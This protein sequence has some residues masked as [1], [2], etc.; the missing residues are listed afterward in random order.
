MKI[1]QILFSLV[2]LGMLGILPAVLAQE[3]AAEGAEGTDTGAVAAE[4]SD[5]ESIPR[6]PVPEPEEEKFRYNPQGARDPFV[7]LVGPDR[8]VSAA[9]RPPGLPGMWQVGQAS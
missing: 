3:P 1:R 5:L 4:M 8:D 2:L 7:P 9:P 6:A